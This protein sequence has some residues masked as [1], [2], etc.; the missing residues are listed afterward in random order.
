MM[1]IAKKLYNY[2]YSLFLENRY[3]IRDKYKPIYYALLY[4]MRDSKADEFRRMGS[5]LQQTVDEI[6]D[7]IKQMQ[8][9]YA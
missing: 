1:L 6:V 3:N 4:F 2:T 8:K 7:Q 9:D 5:E